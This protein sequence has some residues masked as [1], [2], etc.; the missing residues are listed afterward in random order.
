MTRFLDLFA[1]KKPVIGMIHLP[2]LPGTAAGRSAR[3]ADLVKFALQELEALQRGGVDGVIVENFWDLPYLP[4]SVPA[5]TVAAMAAVAGQVVARAQVPVGVNILYN[6]DQAEIAVARA[7][8]AAF[9]RAE[10]FVDPA[11]SETGWIQPSAARLMRERAALD[12]EAVAILADVQ[13]KNTLALWDRPIMES[14]VD[15]ARR[16]LADGIVVTGAGTG[17]P[18]SVELLRQV[19]EAIDIPLL[20]GSGVNPG[21]IGALFE[22]C[23]GAIVGSYFKT[24]GIISAPT[25]PGRVKELMAKVTR[26]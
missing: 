18:V 21:S 26:R 13:G 16:G 19:K 23:D 24:G 12:A 20:A 4:G 11:L 3:Y 8:G 17:Q 10:V 22:T 6:D 1:S 9:L 25:D 15:A 5:I 7:I 14:A 2:A